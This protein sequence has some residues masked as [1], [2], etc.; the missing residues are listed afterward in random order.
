MLPET[1][2]SIIH[3]LDQNQLA[4]RGLLDNPPN[5][6]IHWRPAEDKWCLLEIVCHLIDEEVDDFRMRVKTTLETPGVAPPNIDPEGWVTSRSYYERDYTEMVEQFLNEREASVRWLQS[7]KM[8]EW[9]NGFEHKHF[10]LMTAKLFLSNWLAHDYLHI[11]QIL[12]LKHQFLADT[13]GQDMRYAG[14]W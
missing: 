7:L 4:F 1:V 9:D 5:P 13:S 10:G 14:D 8:P 2:Q 6:L 12:H 11:R 3:S